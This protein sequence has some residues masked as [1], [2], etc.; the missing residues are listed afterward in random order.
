MLKKLQQSAFWGISKEYAD[1][2]WLSQIFNS[3][4]LLSALNVNLFMA[5][6]FPT[7]QVADMFLPIIWLFVPLNF[8]FT[9]KILFFKFLAK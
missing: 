2:C 8:I 6:F 4:L 1:K 3:F 5:D 9:A 7:P